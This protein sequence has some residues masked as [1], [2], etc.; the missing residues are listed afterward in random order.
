[1]S[2][3]IRQL[4]T[5]LRLINEGNGW[6][7]EKKSREGYKHIG[8]I[9]CVLENPNDFWMITEK[10]HYLLDRAWEGC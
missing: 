3:E 9:L 10:D 1:M 6:H 4:S 7:V 2:P 5:T 8:S